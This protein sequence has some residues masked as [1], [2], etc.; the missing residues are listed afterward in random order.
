MARFS[1]RGLLI[2]L[3]CVCATSLAQEQEVPLGDLA[4]ALR[5]AKAARSEEKPV[6]DNDNLPVMMEKAES[7]RLNGKPVFAV[8]PS[9]KTFRMTSPD[10]T[11]SISFDA[12]ATA[13][14]ATPYV[15]SELPQDDLG[16]L[17]GPANVHDGILEVSLHNGTGW[18][19]KEIVVG[20]TVENQPRPQLEQTALET[21]DFEVGT[22]FPDVTTLYHL[23]ASAPPDSVTVFHGTLVGDLD[24][25]KEWHWAIVGARGIPPAAPSITRTD[26]SA[27]AS[28]PV[29]GKPLPGEQSSTGQPV[30]AGQPSPPE[31]QQPRLPL[32]QPESGNAAA[33]IPSR[34][35]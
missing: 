16:K 26:P 30:P 3:L 32:V 27:I 14:I 33:A 22:K 10:G 9:G 15:A 8:D 6:I 12:K 1:L 13:L 31:Q 34:P 17:D 23:R 35:R 20:V 19:L 28:I 2:F 4:R 25:A 11:C 21:G 5:K 24:E 29:P 7:E 18:E